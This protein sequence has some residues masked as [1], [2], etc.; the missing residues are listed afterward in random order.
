MAM[1]DVTLEHPQDVIFQCPKGVGR[2]RPQDVGGGHPLALYRGPYRNVHRISFGDVLRTS[3]ARNFAGWV[4]R[5]FLLDKKEKSN[6]NS[7]Q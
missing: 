5:F 1:S 2:G 6:N 3:S 4:Y 7:H